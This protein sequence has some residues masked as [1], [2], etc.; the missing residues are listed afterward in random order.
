MVVDDDPFILNTL[1]QRFETW[2]IN[3]FG[4]QT[5]EEA[6]A[7]MQKYRPDLVLL[8]LLLDGRAGAESIIHFMKGQAN[9]QRVP[10]VVL[11]NLDDPE[12]K[13][14]MEASGVSDYWI[15]GDMSLDE[16]AERVKKYLK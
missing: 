8:D 4:A 10:I 13:R 7:H 15:K 3:V 12:D 6:I 11:T 14:K 2:S 9:L 1:R 16:L 5:P